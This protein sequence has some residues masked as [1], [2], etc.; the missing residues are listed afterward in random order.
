MA[1]RNFFDE[2]AESTNAF[3]KINPTTGQPLSADILGLYK[4]IYDK[5]TPQTLKDYASAASSALTYDQAAL[6]RAQQGILSPEQARNAQQGAREAWAARG[7]VN[8]NGAIGAEILNREAVRQQMEDRARKQYQQSMD[9]VSS[10]VEMQTGNIFQPIG[11]LISNTFN[12][13]GQYAND[14][15]DYNANAYNAWQNSQAN[16]DAATEAAKL[17]I[18]GEYAGALGSF[19]ANDGLNNTKKFV[20]DLFG[21]LGQGVCWVAREVYGEDDPRWM[22]FREWL[23]LDA[24]GWLRRLYIKHGERFAAFLRRNPWL[25][26]P[27]RAFMDS[28]IEKRKCVPLKEAY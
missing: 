4:G 13:Y 8:S 19:L 2:G 25:K 24:P 23:L 1:V 17:G 6:A 18:Q 22:E 16:R 10:A 12:P 15:Y 9:N 11:T 26:P 5:F 21:W 7:L 3:N 14:V 28:R 27:I 20:K